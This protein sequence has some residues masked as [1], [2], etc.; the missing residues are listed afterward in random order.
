MKKNIHPEYHSIKVVM[1]D[2]TEFTTKS[3]FGKKGQLPH[4]EGYFVHAFVKRNNMQEK[5][6]IPK[7]IK[8]ELSRI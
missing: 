1:T 8:F 6:S 4:A 2:G 5:V 3:T 7:K